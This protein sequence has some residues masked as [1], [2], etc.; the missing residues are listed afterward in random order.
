MIT[1]RSALIK[2]NT[3]PQLGHDIATVT[4]GLLAIT[5]G[6]R[7]AKG[8]LQLNVPTV[9][10]VGGVLVGGYNLNKSIIYREPAEIDI[11]EKEL[12][13]NLATS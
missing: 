2:T 8:G 4:S 7:A 3:N 12:A 5:M 13:K 6:S 11:D 1:T 9:M 10:T